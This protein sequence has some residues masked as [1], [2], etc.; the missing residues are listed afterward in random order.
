M[1]LIKESHYDG[2]FAREVDCLLF[3]LIIKTFNEQVFGNEAFK[4]ATEQEFILKVLSC[5]F[6]SP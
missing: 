6:A 4:N 2:L 1:R 5:I 3:L